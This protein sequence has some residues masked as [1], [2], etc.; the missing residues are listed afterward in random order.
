MHSRRYIM[1]AYDT[2]WSQFQTYKLVYC[3]VV[4]ASLAQPRVQLLCRNVERHT[5]ELRHGRVAGYTAVA[6]RAHAQRRRLGSL[7]RI[8]KCCTPLVNTL[9]ARCFCG[10]SGLQR[11]FELDAVLIGV[12]SCD[13]TTN[14]P[15]CIM[16]VFHR[17]IRRFGSPRTGLML[18][19]P[20]REDDAVVDAAVCRLK[21]QKRCAMAVVC[22]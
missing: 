1:L 20:P 14:L 18:T 2:C 7:P 15:Y 3:W 13:R 21:A 17:N 9:T 19:L 8:L 11:H 22:A 5:A 6:A 10:I 4:T 16:N 12:L